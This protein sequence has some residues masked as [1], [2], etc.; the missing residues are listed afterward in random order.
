MKIYKAVFSQIVNSL[1]C[2]HMHKFLLGEEWIPINHFII[3]RCRVVILQQIILMVALKC[4]RLFLTN[5]ITNFDFLCELL[6]FTYYC[7]NDYAWTIQ[8]IP[9]SGSG[10]TMGIKFVQTLEYRS[11]SG[12]RQFSASFI[13]SC[14]TSVYWL[15]SW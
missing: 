8:K 5:I 13:R 7:S 14:C 2:W 9:L 11:S 4:F 10:H 15:V 6:K 1:N 3:F 12:S